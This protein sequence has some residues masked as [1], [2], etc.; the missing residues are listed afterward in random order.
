ML[1]KQNKHNYRFLEENIEKTQKNT[2]PLA[3]NRYMS[4][5]VYEHTMP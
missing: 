5:I 1:E 3:N 4:I 2:H